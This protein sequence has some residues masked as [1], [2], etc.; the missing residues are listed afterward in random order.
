MDIEKLKL[1]S[2][3]F[4]RTKFERI[5]VRDGK[6]V[7]CVDFRYLESLSEV[8][9]LELLFLSSPAMAKT[10]GDLIAFYG[11][12]DDEQAIVLLDAARKALPDKDYSV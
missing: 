4:G 12:D 3:N 5:F 8:R 6:D 2:Y 10:L 7:A 9:K 11:S 1:K